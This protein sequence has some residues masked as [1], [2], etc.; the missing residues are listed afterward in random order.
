MI[1]IP[2]CRVSM[3]KEEHR[4]VKDVLDSGWLTHG[5]KTLQFEQDFAAYL[6]VGHAIAMNSCTSALYLAI[7]ANNIKGEVMLPSFTFVASANAV[8]TA[9]AKPVF[10]DVNYHDCNINPDLLE[11]SLSSDTEALMIVHFGGQC[12]EMDKIKEFVN[13]HNLL[14]IEDSAETLGGT[15]NNKKSGSWGIGCFSFF[16]T[17]NITTGEGGMFTTDDDQLADKVRTLINHGIDK[18][19]FARNGVKRDWFRVGRLAGYNFRL[20]N[21]LATIGVEQMKKLD[22]MNTLRRKNSSYLIKQL[23]GIEDIELPRE[24]EG[25]THVYQMFTI[26][27]KAEIRDDFVEKL[28]ENGI[29]ASVHFDPP[30]HLHPAYTEYAQNQLPVTERTAESILTLPMFPELKKIELDYIADTIREYYGKK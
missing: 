11:D 6:G 28:R 20:S 21:I 14:L 16:P 5:P 13:K 4:A 9:G 30:V 17:K 27:V 2:L 7:K 22:G 18:S 26:K 8:K 1:K 19:T 29:G 15:F 23:K 25:C 24:N 3:G 10:V 12:C